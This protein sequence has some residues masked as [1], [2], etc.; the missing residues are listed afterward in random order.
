MGRHYAWANATAC[1]KSWKL[2]T[3]YGRIC[4]RHESD[5]TKISGAT[6]DSARRFALDLQMETQKYGGP[7]GSNVGAS[8]ET[9]RSTAYLSV[10]PERAIF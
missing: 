6:G 3:L 2:I 7:M 8:V 1:H 10:G 5:G 4:S 9:F